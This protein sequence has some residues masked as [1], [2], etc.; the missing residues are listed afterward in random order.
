M[1][2]LVTGPSAHRKIL[3][4]S[5]A[6]GKITKAQKVLGMIIVHTCSKAY[7]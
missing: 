3:E 5:G 7:N 1:S 6:L 4:K 2:G